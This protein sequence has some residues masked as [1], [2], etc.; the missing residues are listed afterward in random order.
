MKLEFVDDFYALFGLPQGLVVDLVAL[1]AAY[2]D[3]LARV[4]PDRHARASDLERR[5][6]MQWTTRVN[7]AYSTLK[8]PLSRAIYL[9]S[10]RGMDVR[11][12]SNTA[13]NPEFLAEQMDWREA[14]ADAVA[15][16]DRGEIERIA[17][18]LRDTGQRLESEIE[19]SFDNGPSLE[20]VGELVRRMMFVEKLQQG[21][22]DAL[23]ALDS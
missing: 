19:L 6:A 2:H 20:H 11:A 17:A 12:E 18:Q 14:V 16:S 5:L 3:L 15:A 13:M 23:E 4:H 21:I 8:K 10:L 22:D 7:E 9:L 1:D